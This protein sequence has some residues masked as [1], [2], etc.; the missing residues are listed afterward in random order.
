MQR[1]LTR[2]FKALALRL[3]PL[4]ATVRVVEDHRRAWEAHNARELVRGGDEP[5]WVVL[6]D[7]AAQAVGASAWDR[8]YVGATRTMLEARDGQPWRVVNLSVSGAKTADVLESQIP[9]WRELSERLGV[10]AF[11]SAI[12]GGNDA[13]TTPLDAWTGQMAGVI[14]GLPAGAM[15]ATIPRGWREK[16]VSRYNAWL[17]A[18]AAETDLLLVRL[19]RHTGPPYRG[20]YFDGFHP[21]DRGYEQWNAAIAEAL[22]L[23]WHPEDPAG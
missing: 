8:G 22:G 18:T 21:N 4:R 13:T 20:L 15:I 3:P 6:G 16:R 5:L 17:I 19:D 2:P 9:R 23:R 7:S 1:G 11:V 14:D 12:I 10:P